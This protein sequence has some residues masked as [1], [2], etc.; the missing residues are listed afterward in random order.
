MYVCTYVFMYVC[1]YVGV[2][3]CMM[4][5][6]MHAF[7][8]YIRNYTYINVHTYIHSSIHTFLHPYISK[9]PRCWRVTLKLKSVA[10]EVEKGG[11]RGP[12]EADDENKNHPSKVMRRWTEEQYAA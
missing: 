11:G 3:V 5:V 10:D 8:C 6:C 9:R 12:G 2:Y 1:M 4:Y 7:M